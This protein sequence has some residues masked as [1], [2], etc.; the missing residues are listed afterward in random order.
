MENT[1]RITQIPVSEDNYAFTMENTVEPYLKSVGTDDY[2]KSFDGRP[3]HYE[4]YTLAD[5]LGTVVIVHG[6]TESAEKFREMS[7][8][9]LQMGYN[10][11]AIDNR[12]HGKS[13]R[14][15]PEAPE[16]V[17]V[18][19]FSD[20]VE[21]LNTLIAQVVRKDNAPEPLYLYAHSMGGA[22]S[23]QYLQTYP[24]VFAKAVLSSP[25]IK[26]NTANLPHALVGALASVCTLIGKGNTKPGF[27]GGFDPER[28]YEG[29][30]DTSKAR[31][32][33]YQ[34]K[35]INDPMLR[36]SAPSYKWT[37]EAVRVTKKN[38]DP[39]RCKKI[40]VPVLL[41]KP[42]EDSAVIPEKEDAFISLIPNGRIEK[43][44]NCR[45]EIYASVDDTVLK[46]LQTIEAFLKN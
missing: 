28:G 22:I 1:L 10:V 25:M 36:T 35:R 9:F 23:V 11:Y 7:Y 26:A 34:K 39:A 43:F 38:L 14:L 40:D 18:K 5:P 13:F 27:M 21:D 3:I 32:D 33:Y 44:T 42:E 46:Y 31:F 29:S 37:L 12:G 17:T 16:T 19:Q 41:C 20:Y 8:N 30:H 6:F 4:K 45:H 2:F 15:N 24:G